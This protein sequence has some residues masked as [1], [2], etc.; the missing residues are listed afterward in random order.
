[1]WHLGFYGAARGSQLGWLA[2]VIGGCASRRLQLAPR[3][4]HSGELRQQLIDVPLAMLCWL[5]CGRSCRWPGGL[6]CGWR[7]DLLRHLN[8]RC[9]RVRNRPRGFCRLSGARCMRDRGLAVVRCQQLID[10]QSTMLCWLWCGLSCCWRGD[11]LRHLNDRCLSVRNCP[12]R[13]CR[14]SGARCTRE[15]GLVVVF[16][17]FLDRTRIVLTHHR[18][19]RVGFQLGFDDT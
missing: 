19:E 4:A 13:F 6:S 9:L 11:L 15:R 12:R 5:R 1:M 10:V 18:E 2:L 3:R 7:G 16:G 8:D 17:P 14:L